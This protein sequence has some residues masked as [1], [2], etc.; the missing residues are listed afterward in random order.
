MGSSLIL[1]GSVDNPMICL[2]FVV[3]SSLILVGSVDNP[4]I[5]PDV[6]VPCFALGC[7]PQVV[8]LFPWIKTDWGSISIY[9]YITYVVTDVETL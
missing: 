3:G 4:M 1:V 5:C 8:Y 2:L 6:V 9:I 7:V